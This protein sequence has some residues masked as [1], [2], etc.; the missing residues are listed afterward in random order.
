MTSAK[1]L[2]LFLSS[3]TSYSVF[4]LL[5]VLPYSSALALD[6]KLVNII[7]SLKWSDLPGLEI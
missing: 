7:S 6:P 2:V 1:A 5:G 3:T 4:L